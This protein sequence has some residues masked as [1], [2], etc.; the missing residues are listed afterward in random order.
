MAWAPRNVPT[1]KRSM[2][3]QVWFDIC[4]IFIKLIVTNFPS[5]LKH[6]HFKKVVKIHMSWYSFLCE[7]HHCYRDTS[8]FNGIYCKHT[9]LCLVPFVPLSYVFWC[10]R[11]KVGG[12]FFGSAAPFAT[13]YTMTSN[14]SCNSSVF[15]SVHHQTHLRGS[16]C[17]IVSKIKWRAALC[18]CIFRLP[19]S[20]VIVIVY[21]FTLHY[22]RP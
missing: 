12:K 19:T 18:G 1:Q 13:G 21:R 10:V 14:S 7:Q 8:L 11:F 3:F 22:N 20:E 17:L 2:T 4:F 9:Q 15:H 16:K 5:P 6:V